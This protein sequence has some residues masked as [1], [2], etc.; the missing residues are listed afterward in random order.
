MY[1]VISNRPSNKYTTTQFTNNI[2]VL[3][4]LLLLLNE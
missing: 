3:L 4:V 2:Q 1:L